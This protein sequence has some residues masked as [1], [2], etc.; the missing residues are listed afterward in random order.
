[1]RLIM[2]LAECLCWSLS[3]GLHVGHMFSCGVVRDH[4]EAPQHS[5]LKFPSQ[6][7]VCVKC[8]VRIRPRSSPRGLRAAGAGNRCGGLPRRR[9]RVAPPQAPLIGTRLLSRRSTSMAAQVMLALTPWPPRSAGGGNMRRPPL[10]WMLGRPTHAKRIGMRLISR[11]RTS[12]AAQVT[13][14]LT[15]W[16]PRR[17]AIALH[18]SWTQG[19]PPHAPRIGTRLV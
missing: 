14:A 1:M 6:F 15:P 5:C 17:R 18:V 7:P 13:P 2:W 3:S 8:L 9:C 19:C 12:M 11:R 16:P 10:S 4:A